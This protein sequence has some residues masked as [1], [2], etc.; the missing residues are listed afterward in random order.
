MLLPP[1][2]M[3]SVSDR[4]IAYQ[5]PYAPAPRTVSYKLPSRPYYPKNFIG[6][7][8]YGESMSHEER[9]GWDPEEARQSTIHSLRAAR[10]VLP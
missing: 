3:E 9:Y 5:K 4:F 7:M 8:Q 1:M 10:A 2:K 6:P